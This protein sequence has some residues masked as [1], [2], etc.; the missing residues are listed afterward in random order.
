VLCSVEQC[1]SLKTLEPS[2]TKLAQIFFERRQ[3]AFAGILLDEGITKEQ[4]KTP[5]KAKKKTLLYY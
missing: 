1:E 4:V 5:E 3:K 2:S